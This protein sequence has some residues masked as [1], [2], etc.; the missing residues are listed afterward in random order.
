MKYNLIKGGVAKDFRGSINFVNDFDM[1]EIKRFYIIRNIDCDIIR[2]WRGHRIEQR[3]F[4]VISGGFE[5]NLIQ[6]DDWKSP[7]KDL[8]I[9][10]LTLNAEENCILHLPVGYATTFKATRQDS[11][12]LV[13]S[14]FGIE[15][16]KNDDY[17]FPLDYFVNLR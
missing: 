11:E 8:E 14:D 4:F 13:F 2:G 10:T 5:V 17:T 15:N 16:A 9:E 7:R 3:W 1:T 6:I 12:L